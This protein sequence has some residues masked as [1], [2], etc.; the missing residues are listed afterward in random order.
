MKKNVVLGSM[1]QNIWASSDENKWKWLQMP[2]NFFQSV[3]RLLKF[4][5]FW[6]KKEYSQLESNEGKEK[7]DFITRHFW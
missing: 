3:D 7:L 2:K 5:L 6:V 1:E 4:D